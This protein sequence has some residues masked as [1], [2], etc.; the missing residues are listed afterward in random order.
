MPRPPTSCSP[1]P[2]DVFRGF[3]VVATAVKNLKLLFKSQLIKEAS[4]TEL[5]ALLRQ[6]SIFIPSG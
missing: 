3:G 6:R 4:I 1:L 2:G 5:S